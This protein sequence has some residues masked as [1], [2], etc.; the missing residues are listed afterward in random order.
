LNMVAC[1]TTDARLEIQQEVTQ[2]V[3]Y[4]FDC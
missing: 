2:A 1:L 3:N 4:Y